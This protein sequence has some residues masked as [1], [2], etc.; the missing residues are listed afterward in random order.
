M[1]EG[2]KVFTLFHKHS[3]FTDQLV[4]IDDNGEL[5][6][7]KGQL[8]KFFLQDSSTGLF[9]WLTVI[10]IHGCY[11]HVNICKRD[12]SFRPTQ[13]TRFPSYTESC[14]SD[15]NIGESTHLPL[16]CKY[17]SMIITP[18]CH[19]PPP[20]PPPPGPA[21]WRPSYSRWW[22]TAGCLSASTPGCPLP[23]PPAPMSG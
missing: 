10:L 8:V 16:S 15:V 19:S 7:R 3:F 5:S 4:S 18:N 1:C 22:R 21:C 12:V 13:S 20:S 23:R 6:S 2:L 11:L 9:S 17:H 14:V